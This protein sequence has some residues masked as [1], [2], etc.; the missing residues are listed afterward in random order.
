MGGKKID[1]HS[2]IGTDRNHPFRGD[3]EQ[4]C[5]SAL[6]RNV[7]EAYLFPVPCP[8]Y[9]KNGGYYCPS[10]GEMHGTELRVQAELEKDGVRTILEVPPN[11]FAEYNTLID[12]EIRHAMA[13]GHFPGLQL[14]FVPHVHPLRDSLQHVEEVL[15][16]HPPAVKLHGSSWCFDPLTI[17]SAFFDLLGEYNAKLILHT[18]YHNAAVQNGLHSI[19]RANDPLVWLR[20]CLAHDLRAILAHGARLCKESLDVVN[21]SSQFLVGLSP[22][23]TMAGFRVKR[24]DGDYL[25][26]LCEMVDPDKL[27]FDFDFPWNVADNGKELIWD[28][29]EGLSRFLSESELHRVHYENAASFFAKT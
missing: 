18:D 1:A 2:H 20:L 22:K 11:P 6:L 25:E 15:A 9:P 3:I 7:S 10:F 28:F 14:H 12:Q 27:V 29:D 23:L 19:R 17:P 4:Y 8:R 21:S 5:R 24:W 13:Q 26:L 16:Q